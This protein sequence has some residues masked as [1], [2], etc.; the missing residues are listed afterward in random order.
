MAIP[1]VL[2][3]DQARER[4]RHGI[5]LLAELV[6]CT[7]GPRAGFVAVT[8]DSASKAP[9]PLTSSAI[10]ARRII[11]IKGRGANVGTMMLRH[12]L[13]QMHE[14]L[15]DGGATMA[16]LAHAMLEGGARQVAAG[17]NPMLLR[18]GI[19][20][21]VETATAALAAQARPL[22]GERHMAGLAHA[23]TGD[24]ELSAALGEIFGRFGPECSIRIEEFAASY[25]AHQFL[26]GSA[27]DGTFVSPHFIADQAAS[28]T[29]MHNVRLLLT[30]RTIDDPREL[31][32][33]LEQVV[34]QQAGPLII[35]ANDITGQ[36]RTLL[37]AN[38]ARGIVDV[39][40]GKLTLLGDNRRQTLEDI[41][42]LTNA[43]LFIEERGDRIESAA[44]SELGSAR[45]AQIDNKQVTVVGGGG[46]APLVEARRA[47]TRV[48]LARA[49][50]ED[51]RKRIVERLGKLAGGMAVLKLGAASDSER[52]LRKE[53]AER[54]IRFVPIAL[55]EGV[56]AG[57]GAAFLAC[58]PALDR[59][60]GVG[61]EEAIG[62]LLVR[63]ALAAPM[64]WLVRN[65][66]QPV[67][68]TLA[69]VERHGSGYGYDVIGEQVADMWEA[70]ILDAAKVA[71]VAL[72]TAA[73]IATMVL[74]TDAIVLKRRPVMAREP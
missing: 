54:F 7:L 74:T 24:P 6:S 23:A 30:D 28:R 36:A 70:N 14:Q 72:T 51:E 62:A 48:Q 33:I 13:W 29:R 1:H 64:R 69:E 18:R 39:A 65:A 34:R 57:G 63:D 2:F 55:E 60:A 42:A 25:L 44:L 73:S 17:A 37:L 22:E 21:A 46:L 20:R 47:T 66:H 27:W 10:I 16:A 9:E 68:P 49:K 43:Y 58:R 11:E 50:D 4:L 52:T 12:A 56:V 71:R 3:G 19:N 15:G 5:D 8:R 53:I 41:A 45:I 40:A 61:D 67:A 31:V 38:R 59:L 32:P 26:E 35:I